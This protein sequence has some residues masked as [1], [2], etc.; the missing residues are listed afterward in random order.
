M[1]D[2]SMK[3]E[4]FLVFALVSL[5]SSWYPR[6]EAVDGELVCGAHKLGTRYSARGVRMPLLQ[7]VAST[8]RM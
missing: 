2:C 5:W 1:V 4:R 3:C 6:T 7:N 8:A